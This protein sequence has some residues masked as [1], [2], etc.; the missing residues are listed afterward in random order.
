MPENQNGEVDVVD[1]ELDLSHNTLEVF[2]GSSYNK[3]IGDLINDAL[4]F[5]KEFREWEG[6]GESIEDTPEALMENYPDLF[7]S[8][9][10]AR[11]FMDETGSGYGWFEGERM[12]LNSQ[13]TPDIWYKGFTT[14]EEFPEQKE[15]LD[16]I[17]NHPRIKLG[18]QSR[19]KV[20]FKEKEK[21]IKADALRSRAGEI[22][23][24]LGLGSLED[25]AKGI[26]DIRQGK[27]Q[28]TP[29]ELELLGEASTL[30]LQAEEI[31]E[32]P[33]DVDNIIA[34][35]SVPVSPTPTDTTST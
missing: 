8:T 19:E 7:Q 22:H 4:T 2:F 33:I 13:G 21:H 16:R 15:F 6:Y 17:R 28:F 35:N 1:Y 12:K 9:E 20:L 10:G 11:R 34:S 32:T 23:D 3:H 14:V 18:I 25:L 31:L 24:Q 30:R 29:E 5:R 26:E 27:R